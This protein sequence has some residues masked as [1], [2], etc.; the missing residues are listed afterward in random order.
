ME[1]PFQL[2]VDKET[3][4]VTL[5]VISPSFDCVICLLTIRGVAKGEV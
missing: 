2:S 4:E 1:V 5:F 3:R